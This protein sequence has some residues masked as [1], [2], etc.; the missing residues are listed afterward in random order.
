MG[1]PEVVMLPVALD[2][3]ITLP[4][5]PV[6]EAIH[7]WRIEI[8]GTDVAGEA[9]RPKP[10][11]AVACRAGEDAAERVVE[12]SPGSPGG[13]PARLFLSAEEC[14]R[15]DR[16]RRPVRRRQFVTGRAGLRRLLATYLGCRPEAVP[17]RSG[18]HGRP[19]LDGRGDPSRLAF[20]LS[21]SDRWI[22]IAVYGGGAVG[23][24]IEALRCATPWEAIAKRFFAE[25]EGRALRDVPP[26]ERR[27]AFFRIWVCKEAYA[28]AR[29]E[30]LARG[31]RT[32]AVTVSPAD[33]PRICS[34]E[35]DPR[36]PLHWRL[37]NLDV[38]DVHVAALAWERPTSAGGA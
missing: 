37:R 3:P 38:D 32:F 16:I 14:A 12:G 6:A 34:D 13:H 7:V 30:G 26:A 18:H 36:A 15:A 22:L 2:G 28:K 10:V 17:L 9:R 11:R 21:H 5:E 29:G 19:E 33:R 20:S 1:L 25:G 35:R 8:P 4:A 27:A 23:V 31:F 24:D